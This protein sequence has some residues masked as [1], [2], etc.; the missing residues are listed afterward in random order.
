MISL[1]D[2]SWTCPFLLFFFSYEE[3]AKLR[4]DYITLV[5]RIL[6]KYCKY[7][8]QF[9]KLMQ[10]HIPHQF[11]KEIKQQTKVVS[12]LVMCW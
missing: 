9:A 2:Q 12:P 3:H 5:L 6:V 1:S 11:S 10:D 7:F 4:K 8:K